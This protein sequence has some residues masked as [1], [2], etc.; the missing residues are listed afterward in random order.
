MNLGMSECGQSSMFD[1]AVFL[2]ILLVASS[3]LL[4]LYDPSIQAEDVR[5]FQYLSMYTKRLA[6]AAFSST[7]P[8]A[9]YLDSY[10]EE[11]IRKDVSVQ[12]MV[13]EELLLMSSGVPERNF[14]GPGRYNDR[15]EW[16]LSS[17]MNESNFNC[18]LR[19]ELQGSKVYIIG[20]DN[21]QSKKVERA[22][23]HSEF[24]LPEENLRVSIVLDVWREAPG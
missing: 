11:V 1:A 3:L 15:I 23:Y 4:N 22:S 6:H 13:V 7:V 16:V 17:L 21:I 20:S 18:T 8:N 12:E 19:G 2:T 10:G 9:S 14:V 24:I 5:S